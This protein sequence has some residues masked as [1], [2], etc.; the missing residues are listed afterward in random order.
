MVE[1]VCAPVISEGNI[2]FL[3][4]LISQFH[5][6]YT[7]V[8]TSSWN[9]KD[10]TLLITLNW[11]RNMAFRETLGHFVLKVNTVSLL[12][13][14]KTAETC[15]TFWLIDISMQATY[16][17]GHNYL[18]RD[19]I[20]T[21]GDIQIFMDELDVEARRLLHPL[22]DQQRTVHRCISDTQTGLQFMTNSAILSPGRE[23]DELQFAV[24]LHCYIIRGQIFMF[25]KNQTTVE[26]Y[27]HYHTYIIQDC[28]ECFV[29]SRD[30]VD[31]YVL[32]VYS[33]HGSNAVSLYHLI[34][35]E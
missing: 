21:S 33:L 34:D 26:F 19:E 5:D 32:P 17:S 9:Q 13:S 35:I 3:G 31:P 28:E 7:N 15:V 1:M 14:R 2:V 25:C 12:M 10:I 29:T 23:S 11:Q 4:D 27:W 24:I 18:L 20:E 30:L 8:P 16:L 22:H 6:T